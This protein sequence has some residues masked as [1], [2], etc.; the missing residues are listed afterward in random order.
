M[1]EGEYKDGR[2][3]GMGEKGCFDENEVASSL[4]LGKYTWANGKWY[5]GEFKSGKRSGYGVMHTG[6]GDRYEGQWKAGKP[7][8]EGALYQVS[9]MIC[10]N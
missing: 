2:M 6:D 5:E 8:G 3:E 4:F 9:R 10:L 7:V 1:Y